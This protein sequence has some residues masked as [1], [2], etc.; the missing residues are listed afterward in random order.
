MKARLAAQGPP[1]RRPRLRVTVRGLMVFV[2]V[3][4]LLMAYGGAYYR[5]SRRGMHEAREFGIPGPLYVPF[6]EAAESED[7]T[8][9]YA[10]ATFYAPLNWIDRAIF[11]APS[12][13]I[14]IMWRLSG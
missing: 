6:A 9:H 13:R 3:C 5:P 2:A 1:P 10:L 12:P 8:R 7:L 14:S 11:G 4:S